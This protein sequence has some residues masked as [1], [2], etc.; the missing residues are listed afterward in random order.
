MKDRES[1][2]AIIII[3]LAIL[4]CYWSYRHSLWSEGGPGDG[5]FPFLA[6]LA[7]G[8]FG[9]LLLIQGIRNPQAERA[10]V[11]EGKDKAAIYIGSLI[12]YGLLF[13]LLGFILTSVLFMLV[14]CK[15]AE[16]AGWK[17]SLMT[18]ALSTASLYIIFH[19]M[20]VPFPLG[21]LNVFSFLWAS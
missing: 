18:S 5:L 15:W 13:Q 3:I 19:L 7:L 16:R 11:G 9:L 8:F 20:E 2:T 14:I 21:V 4:L 6:G 10:V 12:A 17:A 1:K